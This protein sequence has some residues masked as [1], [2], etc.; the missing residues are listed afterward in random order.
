[1]VGTFNMVSAEHSAN[2]KRDLAEGRSGNFVKQESASLSVEAKAS[3]SESM[4]VSDG[5][6]SITASK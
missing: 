1:M 5:K 4:K 2:C 6:T 3:S